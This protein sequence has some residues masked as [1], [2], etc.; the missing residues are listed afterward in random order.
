MFCFLKFT[1]YAGF[2]PAQHVHGSQ[3]TRVEERTSLRN[4]S[5]S[6]KTKYGT[7]FSISD[8][9]GELGGMLHWEVDSQTEGDSESFTSEDSRCSEMKMHREMKSRPENTNVSGEYVETERVGCRRRL[10][11]ID[12]VDIDDRMHENDCH[13]NSRSVDY[14]DK[15][16]LRYEGTSSPYDIDA[17]D[18][19]VERNF[20]MYL[21]RNYCVRHFNANQKIEQEKEFQTGD[22]TQNSHMYENNHYERGQYD[23]HHITK[24]RYIYHESNCRVENKNGNQDISHAQQRSLTS[25]QNRVTM[26]TSGNDIGDIQWDQQHHVNHDGHMQCDVETFRAQNQDHHKHDGHMQCDVETYRAQNQDHHKHD[27]HMQC[28]AEK[29][30]AQNQDHHKQ[31]G[32]MQCDVETYRAQNQ[33]HHKHDGHMQSDVETYRAQNQD[34]HKHDGHM[35]CDVEIYRA[36][37]QDLHKHDG[38]MQCDVETYRAQN[39]DHHKHD[40]HMQSD[41]ETYWA[42]N[43]DHHR[44]DGHMQSDVET[45]RTQNQDHHRH[46][47]HMQCDIETYR[48]QNQDHHKHDG[49]MQCDVETYRAHNQHHHKQ[50]THVKQ[51]A[52]EHTSSRDD[53]AMHQTAREQQ[54]HVRVSSSHDRTNGKSKSNKPRNIFNTCPEPLELPHH[55]TQVKDK[56]SRDSGFSFSTLEGTREVVVSDDGVDSRYTTVDK[57]D[58]IRVVDDNTGGKYTSHHKENRRGGHEEHSKRTEDWIHSSSH[59]DIRNKHTSEGDTEYFPINYTDHTDGYEGVTQNNN[60]MLK[61]RAAEHIARKTEHD[62]ELYFRTSKN[63]DDIKNTIEGE[64]DLRTRVGRP[65]TTDLFGNA[66]G[67]FTSTSQLLAN[68]LDDGEMHI[69][70]KGERW[71]AD[72]NLQIALNKPS[73]MVIPT[74]QIGLQTNAAELGVIIVSRA[75]Q[76]ITERKGIIQKGKG[77]GAVTESFKVHPGVNFHVLPSDVMCTEYPDGNRSFCMRVCCAAI[78][79]QLL[80]LLLLVLSYF[81]PVGIGGLGCLFSNNLRNSMTFMLRYRDG[82]PPM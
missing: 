15:I 6:N 1:D 60:G 36:Q 28:D 25:D 62:T 3:W 29:Y 38:H 35:Q 23:M 42:Q 57:C 82:A 41:V 47:G 56:C 16:N 12:N 73:K 59:V 75:E 4:D 5:H 55:K 50:Q 66:S 64:S 61:L 45:Y 32:H 21:M 22:I 2:S 13:H 53:Q 70:R 52:Q 24:R 44:H 54:V 31:D 10:R 19:S 51:Y 69:E 72:S 79:L 68:T 40:G 48:A 81:L 77:R 30:R 14:T 65:T 46:D 71:Q 7:R 11:Y 18:N 17:S 26:V 80:L 34:L 74:R 27:G 37:N 76:E 49:H 78:P 20:Q 39:Q 9:F 33:D 43:Q 58:T 67:I 8:T 63:N